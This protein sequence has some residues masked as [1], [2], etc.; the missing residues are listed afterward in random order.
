[1]KKTREINYN[2]PQLSIFLSFFRPHTKL[3][4]LDMLCALTASVIDLVFPYV[5]RLSMTELLPDRQVLKKVVGVFVLSFSNTLLC[6]LSA[7]FE[8]RIAKVKTT[9]CL[10]ENST[11]SQALEERTGQARLLS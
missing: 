5:S 8:L 6:A 9:F 11:L 10:C 4:L 2:G 1:M 7:W 3:F